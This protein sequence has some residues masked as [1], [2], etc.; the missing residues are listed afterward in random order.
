MPG[1]AREQLKAAALDIFQAGLAAASPLA[2]VARC[3]T[4]EDETLVVTPAAG[5]PLRVDLRRCDRIVVV[6]GGKAS[7]R[8]N[9]AVEELLGDRITGGL[10][11]VKYGHRAPSQRVE[12]REAGH[13]VPDQ[14]GCDGAAAHG[15]AARA[16]GPAGPGVL[17]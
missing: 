2:A 17:A 9:C 6:G 5:E 7:A 14:A 8:M 11:V 4:L 13:P 10:I 15:L 16:P 1:R 3:L 12:V